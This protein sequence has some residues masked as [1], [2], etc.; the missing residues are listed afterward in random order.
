DRAAVSASTLRAEIDRRFGNFGFTAALE[1]F[2]DDDALETDDVAAGGYFRRDGLRVGLTLERR[3]I[4]IPFTISSP[5]GRTFDREAELDADGVAVDVRF[6]VGARWSLAAHAAD[7][8]Y[9]RDL[10]IVPRI[11]R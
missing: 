10:V 11:E 9:E 3:D 7:F 4:S 1:R 5:L 8:A 2:G 6:A